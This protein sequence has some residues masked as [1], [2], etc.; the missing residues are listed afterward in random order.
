MKQMMIEYFNEIFET[1]LIRPIPIALLFILITHIISKGRIPFN[2]SLQII[3]WTLLMYFA[4]TILRSLYLIGWNHHHTGVFVERLSNSYGW[5]YLVMLFGNYILPLTLLNQKLGR[6]IYFLLFVSIL[7][8][9]GWIIEMIIILI[10][11]KHDFINKHT[12]AMSP[13]QFA[14]YYL[15]AGLILFLVLFMI[16]YFSKT[17]SMIRK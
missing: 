10:A 9:I 13:V 15:G 2:I 16:D 17:K 6:N 3:R 8:Q 11:N 12:Q 4:W 7:I 14:L 1:N 5:A